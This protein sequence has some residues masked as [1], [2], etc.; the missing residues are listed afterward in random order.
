[1]SWNFVISFSRPGR[2]WNL[3]VGHGK[4]C[5]MIFMGQKS[6]GKHSPRKLKKNDQYYFA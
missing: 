2:A 1:M 4:A 5:K 6:P 3:I